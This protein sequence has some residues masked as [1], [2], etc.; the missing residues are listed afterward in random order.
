[1]YN[2]SGIERLRVARGARD[3][4]KNAIR[5]RAFPPMSSTADALSASPPRSAYRL[6]AFAACV[7][8]PAAFGLLALALGQ[9]ANWDLRNYHYYNP[10]A[11]LTGRWDWDIGAGQIATFYNPLLDVPFY[12]AVQALPPRGVGFLL[13]A[14]QGLNFVLLFFL[15]QKLIT[16][17]SPDGKL[18]ASVAIALVG[19]LG[20]G[21]LSE[22]G[23][24]FHDNLI[25]LLVLG[26]L[27]ILVAQRE[28]LGGANVKTAFAIIAAAG[29]LAGLAA[30]LKQPSV[31]YA[32]GL[33]L[34]CFAVPGRFQRRFLLAFVFG[35]GVLTGIALGG[36]FWMA[37]MWERYGNPLFPYFNHVFQSPYAEIS[38]YRD[39]KF[40]PGNLVEYIFFPVIFSLYSYA[41]AEIPFRD[42][43]FLVLFALL[44]TAAAFW[45]ARQLRTAF[46]GTR[47][48]PWFAKADA[49]TDRAGAGIVLAAALAAY[50]VWLYM[51]AIYRYLIPLELLAPLCIV[52]V[53]DR[54]PFAPAGKWL[55]AGAGFALILV[56]LQPGTWGRVAWG[57]EYFGTRA[58]ALADPANTLVLMTG[59]APTSFVIP[60][61]PPEVR[62]LR[63]QSY[64]TTP[65]PLYRG[66]TPRMRELVAAHRGPLYVLFGT[67]AEQ[68]GW[69]Q[70]A[71]DA[72]G[73]EL[74]KEQCQRVVSRVEAA[75]QPLVL[76]P[77]ARRQD[78]AAQPGG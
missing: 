52:L 41:A 11:L 8:A 15:A 24:V 77:V 13:G 47:T 16:V 48:R 42:V 26:S 66:L 65:L 71:M 6:I 12:W 78:A 34:A 40:Q 49:V 67:S 59:S 46:T 45:I 14:V 73:L 72:Y 20:A 3:E 17:P 7:L 75:D 36:G 63:I 30:G 70:A 31:V 35:L 76:C 22:L 50:G 58:P 57:E 18:A 74:R 29:L 37:E 27:S 39:H 4:Y 5:S 61:F 60:A 38:D 69:T 10:H 44:A 55:G 32:V 9:D 53:L 64:F 51:F 54:I 1:M 25:S 62:F 56:M 2:L 23:T 33:C 28:R 19:M 68:D 21:N 43:R